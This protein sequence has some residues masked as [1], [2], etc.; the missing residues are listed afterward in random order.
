[1]ANQVDVILGMIQELALQ[2]QQS[3]TTIQ[4]A[5]TIQTDQVARLTRRMET[6]SEVLTEY[7]NGV[8]NVKKAVTD[9]PPIINNN[10]LSIRN[11]LK[12]QFFKWRN[13]QGLDEEVACKRFLSLCFPAQKS[14]IVQ[15]IMDTDGITLQQKLDRIQNRVLAISPAQIKKRFY[16]ISMQ[17]TESYL[18]FFERIAKLAPDAFED[19]AEAATEAR[20]KFKSSYDR[21]RP[22][23]GPLYTLVHDAGFAALN[24]SDIT[25]RILEIINFYGINQKP[26]IKIPT[27]PQPMDESDH[28]QSVD[29]ANNNDHQEK[30]ENDKAN[31]LGS[32]A[33]GPRGKTSKKSKQT[34]K[35]DP[36]KGVKCAN[37]HFS[38][39]YWTNEW[40][41]KCGSKLPA[42]DKTAPIDDNGSAQPQNAKVSPDRMHI[43][44]EISNID[45]SEIS[46]P[47]ILNVKLGK[48]RKIIKSLYDGGSGRTYMLASF[49]QHL[50]DK[51]ILPIQKLEPDLRG[52]VQADG[53]KLETSKIV[54]NV[55]LTLQDSTKRWIEIE[56][57]EIVIAQKLNYGLLI[58]RSLYQCGMV[59]Q[60][61]TKKDGTIIIN[62]EAEN[63]IDKSN[64]ID[65]L[66]LKH[67]EIQDITD[68]LLD[69]DAILIGEE[70]EKI[71]PVRLNNGENA[72]MSGNRS[73]KFR[74]DMKSLLNQN[75]DIIDD[76]KVYQNKLY[77]AELQF[78]HKP[79][80]VPPFNPLSPKRVDIL[81]QKINQLIKDGAC[82][83][84]SKVAN[85]NLFLVPKKNG[86][87][88]ADGERL[89]NDLVSYNKACLEYEYRCTSPKEILGRLGNAKIYSSTDIKDAY[90]T[91]PIVCDDPGDPPIAHCPG[92]PFNIEY[93]VLAQGL[94]TAGGHFLASVEAAFPRYK[95]SSFMHNY[96]DDQLVASEDEQAHVEHWKLVLE[97]YRK[98]GLKVN[99]KKTRFGFD[100]IEFLNFKISHGRIKIGDAHKVAIANISD[101]KSVESVN[102][103]LTYFSDFIGV[104]GHYSDLH[105]LRKQPDLGWTPEK[106]KALQSIKTCLVSAGA[107]VIPDFK[108]AMHI[109][110]DASD[111][112]YAFAVCVNKDRT[113]LKPLSKLKTKERQLLP[114]MFFARDCSKIPSWQNKHAYQREGCAASHA[115]QKSEYFV[116]GDHPVFLYIDNKAIQMAM[117]SRSPKVRAMFHS[118]PSNVIPHHIESGKNLTDILSR[119]NEPVETDENDINDQVFMMGTRNRPLNVVKPTTQE[120]GIMKDKET[121][122][123][124]ELPNCPRQASDLKMGSSSQENKRLILKN[125]LLMHQRGGHCSSDRLYRLNAAIYDVKDRP[126]RAQI[127]LI[128][129]EC[130]CQHRKLKGARIKTPTPVP[131]GTHDQIY[132]DFKSVGN[133]H[134]LSLLE[135]L[136]GTYIPLVVPNEKTGTLISKITDFL[137]IFGHVRQF[138]ADNG[139][140][141]DSIEFREFCM[142]LNIRLTF[143]AIYNPSAN[144]TERPH[145]QVNRTFTL[146]KEMGQKIN[147]EDLLRFTWTN[148][149]LPKRLTSKSPVEILFGGIPR[150]I[151]ENDNDEE[152]NLA[153][154]NEVARKVS[155]HLTKLAYDGLLKQEPKQQ[156]EILEAGQR[157]RWVV[158]LKL[159]RKSRDGT[160]ILSN[161]GT[162][163]FVKFD[164]MKRPRWVSVKFLTK[165]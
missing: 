31:F 157:V 5:N 15:D 132:L 68:E 77:T 59:D 119:F 39:S 46:K 38:A 163:C 28:V 74:E 143:T 22:E 137:T 48:N 70:S 86:K 134:I 94:K 41:G 98:S 20:N 161:L 139:A 72:L 52:A 25:T 149:L 19:A 67:D 135:P 79:Q 36:P 117:T 107:L 69:K 50:I 106:R 115:L 84:S 164:N 12:E 35:K 24:F 147:R 110:C 145:S 27:G 85:S 13:L 133:I 30:T 1:M 76:K 152:L 14:A 60:I 6:M 150:G 141:F 116:C 140:S 45:A 16:A 103:F 81:E 165:L 159:E 33:K 146:A 55:K 65:E 155:D 64:L 131:A 144:R 120:N 37:G 113:N 83:K 109:L 124:N 47:H 112:G 93:Q 130:Y 7:V 49:Y 88:G 95:Y 129:Q 21:A 58:G 158:Q 80:A 121:D 71:I 101:G 100:E 126:T 51:Q 23:A 57:P 75:L 122:D 61:L 78:K 44:D 26:E 73:I 162:C 151:F 118:L 153:S 4:T 40:C 89:V 9:S 53:S 136:S 42:P 99:L 148:N 123:Q 96:M 56:L 104:Q 18:A 142:R 125:N 66:T 128:L 114:C 11:F 111:S 97:G 62:P 90:H 82:R 29:P 102:G 17:K 2:Q 3:N 43:L 10:T 127:D 63:F 138:R 156:K 160:V 91:V 34:S 87:E 154:E 8:S 105:A 32:S 108:R 92:L 54:K